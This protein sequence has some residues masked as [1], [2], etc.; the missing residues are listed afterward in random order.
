MKNSKRHFEG[1]TT[2]KSYNF[3]LDAFKNVSDFN[4]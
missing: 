3:M 1:G 2:E 4:E